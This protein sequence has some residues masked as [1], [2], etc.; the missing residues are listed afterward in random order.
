MPIGGRFGS[1]QATMNLEDAWAHLANLLA[2][3][4]NK[5]LALDIFGEAMR[6]PNQIGPSTCIGLIRAALLRAIPGRKRE[7]AG[8]R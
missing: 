4:P 5:E 6:N 1:W 7:G 3:H 2:V 8:A